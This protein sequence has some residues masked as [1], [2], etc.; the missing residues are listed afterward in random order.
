MK[1]G[2]LIYEDNNDFREA[3]VQ[4]I[5][6]S[7]NYTCVGAFYDCTRVVEDIRELKPQVV[8]MDIEMPERNG[9]EAMQLIRNID[10][11]IKIIML[12][13]FDDNK[14][15]L[16][17]IGAGASGYYAKPR[18][19]ELANKLDKKIKQLHSS[20][21][22]NPLA[23]PPGEVLVVGA[24]ASGVQ[25]AIDVAQ[26]RPAI[27]AGNFTTKI[28]DAVFKYFGRFYWWFIGNV[29]TINTRIGRKVKA[30]V[31][32]GGG[33]PLVNV[34]PKDVKAAGI[35][36]VPRVTDVRYGKPVLE[37]GRII[38]PAAIIWCT[39]FKPDFSWLEPS[40]TDEMGY[41]ICERGISSVLDGLYFVEMTFQF[42]LTSH[43]IGGVGEM[44]HLL[45]STFMS[46]RLYKINIRSKR[47]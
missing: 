43:L 1:T 45:Q 16:S 7:E 19:P 40:A 39:G 37:D 15:V 47:K 46:I 28:P 34:S 9:I 13:V 44:L 10:K 33:G 36:H 12:T 25:I 4:L 3:L 6:I 41:P 23:L 29:L 14:N 32:K 35:E 24:G 20:E 8:L 26:Y 11:E 30:T 21:Y 22:T 31:M 42:A 5:N 27:I 18:I 38:S 17:A 2:I